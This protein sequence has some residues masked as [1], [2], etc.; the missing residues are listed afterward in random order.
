MNPSPSRFLAVCLLL[1]AAACSLPQAAVP[2]VPTPF[3]LVAPEANAALT[4]TP[5][6]PDSELAASLAPTP[7]PS[8]MA[9]AQQEAVWGHYP[10]PLVYP[11]SI[12]IPPPVGVLPQPAGQVNILLLGSDQRPGD[13]GFRTD[14]IILAT[15]NP[16]LGTVNLTS[17]PRD[18]YVYIPGW[19]MQRIN[20]AMA[21]GGFDMLAL[22]FEYNLGVRPDY[23]VMVRFSG[24]TS[25]VDSLGGIQVNVAKPLGDQRSGYS[26]YYV[27]AGS[28][29]MDG[30]TALWY[31][32]SRGT[33]NDI[34]RL[35]RS[36]EVLQ[37]IGYKLLS[38]NAL[39]RVPELY[40]LYRQNVQTNLSLENT[41]SLLPA[42]TKL[43][44]NNT[45]NRY[46]I[47]YGQV[48]DWVE[49]YTGAQ[50]LLPNQAAVLQVMRQA[51]NVP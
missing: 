7:A 28:V 5:F 34:E 45:V 11:A 44:A 17:I 51:L 38:L 36:Q 24:F 21:R 20:T 48:Y 41:L 46:V 13:T 1:A 15:L 49:P 29:S 3:Y 27:P 14:T 4:P 50:V 8:M 26:W 19:T 33:S 10:G 37:A 25:I 40:G 35:T 47:G 22:T 39:A 2:S 18:L 31:V 30:E 42:V 6:L 16:T 43:A 12:R 23:Y 32:R 9:P